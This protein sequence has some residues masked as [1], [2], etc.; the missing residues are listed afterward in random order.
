[1]DKTEMIR[2][3]L[4]LKETGILSIKGKKAID[5]IIKAIEA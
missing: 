5:D 1:M 3:L 4:Q 2:F